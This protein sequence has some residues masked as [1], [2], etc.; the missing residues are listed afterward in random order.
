MLRA[1]DRKRSAAV[2]GR[3]YLLSNAGLLRPR[4]VSRCFFAGWLTAP[5]FFSKCHSRCELP[6]PAS[7]MEA[8]LA[9]G[10][11]WLAL[12]AA[13]G[14]RVQDDIIAHPSSAHQPRVGRVEMI[15]SGTGWGTWEIRECQ[16]LI[17]KGLKLEEDCVTTIGAYASVST[18]SKKADRDG[19]TTRH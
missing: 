4:F 2:C 15:L 3:T 9:G 11:S 18:A 14:S 12:L 13:P 5:P 16:F 7:K 6:F 19:A 17:G 8:L 10:T 1:H